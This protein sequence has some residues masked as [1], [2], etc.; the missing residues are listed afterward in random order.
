MDI[1]LWKPYF[2]PIEALWLSTSWVLWSPTFLQC[3]YAYWVIVV[4]YLM[5]IM[6]TYVPTMGQ[7]HPKFQVLSVLSYVSFIKKPFINI[8][9]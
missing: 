3:I 9:L 1:Y 7:D 5:S 4:T 2:M 8:T 6:V